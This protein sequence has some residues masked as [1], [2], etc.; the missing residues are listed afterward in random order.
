MAASR[1]PPARFVALQALQQTLQQGNDLQFAL[2]FQLRRLHVSGKDANLATELCYGY[3]RN[4][5]RVAFCLE[6]FLQ[7]PGKLPPLCRTAFELAT[8]ETLF[9]ERIPEFATRSWLANLVRQQWGSGLTRLATAYMTNIFKNKAALN[10]SEFYQKNASDARAFLSAFYSLPLWIVDLWTEAYGP[11]TAQRLAAA[12]IH[13]APLGL[14]INPL[15]AGKDELVRQYVALEAESAD[16]EIL[17]SLSVSCSRETARRLFPELS[18]DIKA[19]AISRQSLESQRIL[20]ELGAGSWG[21]PI[22]DVCAGRGGKTCYLLERGQK[23]VRA[24]DPNP[25]R[26]HGL[27]RELER[28]GLPPIPVVVARGDVRLPWQKKPATILLDVPCSGL[29]VLS[30]KSD[31]KWKRTPKDIPPLIALQDQLLRQSAEVLRPGGRIVYITCTLNPAENQ[32]RIDHFLGEHPGFSITKRYETQ[33]NDSAREFF[34]GVV[35]EKG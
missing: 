22:W 19:G 18:A 28:L 26:V 6:H 35:L 29:G 20:K 7:K 14:R 25:F 10:A 34:W 9:L 21:E 24:S 5:G 16:L 12:Q 33:I 30:R 15:H 2:D 23:Q 4:K 32:A 1:T 31:I 27:S 8:Y 3:L 13:P 17:D 11:E